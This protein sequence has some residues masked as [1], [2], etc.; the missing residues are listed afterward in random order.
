[1]T[2]Y[3]N[4]VICALGSTH[5]R[6]GFSCG[7]EQ[8]D[9]YLKRQAKQDVKRRISSV[10]IASTPGSPTKIAGYYSL[11]SLSIELTQLSEEVRRKLP[12]HPIPGALVGRLA[13]SQ[14]VQGHGIGRMLLTD[15]IK[16]TLAVSEDIAIYAMVVDAIDDSAAAF[17]QQYGFIPLETGRRRLYLPIK[18]F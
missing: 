2:D 14:T 13:V 15:A 4:Q 8:L 11:S 18:S 10:F 17:Y 5:D 1:M 6:S 16:R 12:R 3:N 9:N 7:N